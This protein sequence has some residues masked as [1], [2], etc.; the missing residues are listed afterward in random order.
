MFW[1][2]I[3]LSWA[4]S[5]LLPSIY[6]E[7]R[8]RQRAYD[9]LHDALVRF[10]LSPCEGR[11]DKPHAYLR[12]IAQNLTMDEFRLSSRYVSLVTSED[13]ERH[14]QSLYLNAIEHSPEQLLQLK[15]RLQ[16]LQKV[17]DRLPPKCKETFWLFRIDGL[18]QQE[19]AQKMSIS[20]NMVQRHL[21][22]AMTDLL[23]AQEYIR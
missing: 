6:R 4:Y 1:Y 12:T 23:E 18:S 15:Q 14:E 22:R 9:I 3:D 7:T 2:G 17:I 16:A 19:I 10:A 5:H 20:V 21:L 11:H 13:A 8:C